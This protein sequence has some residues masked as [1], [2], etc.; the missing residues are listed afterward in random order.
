MLLF[1]PLKSPAKFTE[2]ASHKS[3]AS[4]PQKLENCLST[5]PTAASNSW[6]LHLQNLGQS[7]WRSYRDPTASFSSW[8]Q[9]EPFLNPYPCREETHGISWLRLLKGKIKLRGLLALWA[10]GLPFGGGFLSS[11]PPVQ[12][13]TKNTRAQWFW[14]QGRLKRSRSPLKAFHLSR[15][16]RLQATVQRAEFAVIRCH[17]P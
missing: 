10:W 11:P 14:G 2:S 3:M 9:H 8:D 17:V 6:T 15:R 4:L 12:H 16:K 13:Q 7:N 5:A 1:L